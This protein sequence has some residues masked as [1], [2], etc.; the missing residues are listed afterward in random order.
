MSFTVLA[1]PQL[2]SSSTSNSSIIVSWDPV[3]H[4]VQY[5]LSICKLDSNTSMGVYNT[6]NTSLTFSGL[7]AGSLYVITCFAWDLEGRKGDSSNVKQATRKQA[8][9]QLSVCDC[10]LCVYSSIQMLFSKS[11]GQHEECLTMI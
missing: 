8:L 3:A 10:T 4:A 11:P 1:P 2:S 6:S 9:R 7:D 5:T